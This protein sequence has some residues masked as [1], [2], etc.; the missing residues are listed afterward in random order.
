MYTLCSS[1]F[2]VFVELSKIDI[3]K[4]SDKTM[5]NE[6]TELVLFQDAHKIGHATG[7]SHIPRVWQVNEDKGSRNKSTVNIH[8]KTD[9]D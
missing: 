6:V 9:G 5:H 3:H 2:G 4:F 1:D 7:T 8:L